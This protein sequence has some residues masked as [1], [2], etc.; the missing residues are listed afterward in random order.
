[1]RRSLHIY[2]GVFLAFSIVL[3][4]V[5]STGIHLHVLLEHLHADDPSH[6][7]DVV[8]H[9]HEDSPGPI[10]RSGESSDAAHRH[11]VPSIQIVALQPSSTQGASPIV[12]ELSSIMLPSFVPPSITDGRG[13]LISTDASPHWSDPFAE[14]LSGRSPPLA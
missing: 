3:A 2:L 14:N 11:S 12:I 1:M 4:I 13:L 6:L 5:T 10:S 8:V 9:A 7:P